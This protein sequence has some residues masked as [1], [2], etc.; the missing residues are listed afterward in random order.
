MLA[1]PWFDLP[2]S[3]YGGIEQVCSLLVDSLVARGHR[4]TLFGAG[5]GTHTPATYARTANKTMSDRVGQT[6][7]ELAH[8][9]RADRML[10]ETEFDIVHDHTNVGLLSAIRRGIPT[11]AT[12]HGNPIGELGDFL[13]CIDRE[14]GLVSI[15]HAQRNLN[16][17]LPWVGTVHNG[18]SD[19]E[20]P[21]SEPGRGPVLWL[22]RFIGDKGPELAIDACRAA[23]LPLVLA[24]KCNEEVERRYLDEV[25]QPKLGP[26]VELVING[27]RQ[28]IRELMMQARCLLLPLRWEEPFGMVL[29]EA[30]ASGTPV[31][32]LNRG[33]APEVVA[34]G[35]TGFV[36]DDTSE[37]PDALRRTVDLDPAECVAHVRDRFAP[38]VMAMRYEHI[39]RRW[40]TT[41][42]PL[43]NLRGLQSATLR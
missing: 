11:V 6:L 12:V 14:I 21:K 13:S 27:G 40:A 1:P 9:A 38:D 20:P 29:V 30:M 33:S 25:I 37:L 34:H 24:G 15:S 19:P 43:A 2:P 16:S 3:G 28:R 22:A 8:V 23:G 41:S 18:F 10:D 42:A 39:Y 32:T 31:V 26:D 4:V 36:C 7:P 17:A 5:T 35:R